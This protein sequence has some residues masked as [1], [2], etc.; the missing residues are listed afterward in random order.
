V[1][2]VL[3]YLG[4]SYALS[5]AM[6]LKASLGRNYGAPSFDVWPVYQKKA[7][8]FLSN[9]IT[10][11]DLWKAQKPELSE[12]L[13]LGMRFD[14][15]QFW[16]EPSLYLARFHDKKVSFDSDGSG[17]LP[18]YS[19][20]VGET[21]AWGAQ[22]AGSWTPVSNLDLFG[23]LSW[24]RNEFIE[25]LPVLEAADLNVKGRQIP[26]TPIWMANLGLTWHT[27]G[28]NFAPI[29]RY[30]GARYG[31][32]EHTQRIP[33]FTTLDLNLGYQ[34]RL[35]FGKLNLSFSVI[36]LF[37]RDYI[38]VMRSG[39]YQLLSGGSAIYYPGAPRT[40]MAKIAI[41]I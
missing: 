19:Q 28:F 36:N 18:T 32:T 12:A 21:R 7:D 16:L 25:N 30:T 4:V 11:N 34:H 1:D 9:G 20:N 40:L 3:P 26:D 41:D 6:T 35:S 31:D 39:Y 14:G 2:A 13:D 22:L 17:S 33:A 29:A 37:D 23:G 10:A 8:L 5:P 38:S 15:A 24:N 27:G